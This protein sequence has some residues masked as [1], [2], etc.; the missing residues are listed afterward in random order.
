MATVKVFQIVRVEEFVDFVSIVFFFRRCKRGEQTEI[1]KI[2][3][4][5]ICNLYKVCKE[6]V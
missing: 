4:R 5:K 6:P 3:G 2:V 1:F